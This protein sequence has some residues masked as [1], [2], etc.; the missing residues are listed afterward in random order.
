MKQFNTL[1]LLLIT[2]EFDT[3][4]SFKVG[5]I[6]TPRTLS[7]LGPPQTLGNE[8]GPLANGMCCL[9]GDFSLILI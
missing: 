8:I 9:G 3:L 1:L 2:T 7:S 5:L 6:Q 4:S